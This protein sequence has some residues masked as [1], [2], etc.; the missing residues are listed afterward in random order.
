MKGLYLAL[1]VGSLIVPFIFSF[2]PKIRF[3]KKFLSLFPAMFISGMLYLSW[4]IIF[5]QKG[6]W[7][8]N[9]TYLLGINLLNLPVEEWLFFVCIPFASVFTHY[10]L[11]N[12]YPSIALGPKTTN[13]ISF[14]LLAMLLSMMVFHYHK[15][16]TFYNALCTFTI[17]LISIKLIPKELSTFYITFL[18]VLAPFLVVNG[19]LT[20]S[21]ITDQIVWYND[22]E[23][24]G[25]RIFTIPIEDAFY[26]LGMLLL[27]ILITEQI[28]K[29]RLKR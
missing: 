14:I 4:D 16:Y 11:I 6:Y 3:H 18:I 27:T 12:F 17:L 29:K 20:G 26:A 21:F 28:D 9:D 22:A 15:A 24:L 25:V 2:H 1:D 10:T 7:G 8:F 5:T 13:I 19:V 23:N